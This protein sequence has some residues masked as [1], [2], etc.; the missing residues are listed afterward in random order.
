MSADGGLELIDHCAYTGPHTRRPV[1]VETVDLA[2]RLRSLGIVRVYASRLEALWFENPHDAN[3]L[4][5]GRTGDARGAEVIPVPVVDPTLPTWPEELDRCAAAGPIPLVRLHPNYHR[6]T[7]VQ[8]DALLDSLAKRKIIAQV[9]ARVEDPRR[10]HP[11][12]RVA[13]VAGAEVRDAAGRHP[14]LRLLVSG[15]M[16]PAVSGLARSLPQSRNLWV[17]TGQ[18]DGVDALRGLTRSELRE[19]LV[20]GTNSPLFVAEAALTR[21]LTDLDDATAEL[22]LA[23]NATRLGT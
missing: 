10:Q 16:S 18:L 13:D 5:R 8:A 23:G 11:L 12:A 3:R 21:V 2:V 4:L 19:R 14:T 20:F 15:L 22:I 17:E 1:G 7:L 6:Y 9:V